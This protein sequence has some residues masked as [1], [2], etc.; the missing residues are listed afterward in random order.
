MRKHHYIVRY[1][2]D[3]DGWWVVTVDGKPGGV[4]CVSQGRSLKQARSRIREA[5]ALC[6]DDEKAAKEAV[7]DEH[8]E[9]GRAVKTRLKRLADT[10]ERL[11]KLR[12]EASHETREAAKILTDQGLSMRDA[13]ELLGVSFQRVQQLLA[14][15]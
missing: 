12:T 11:E 7:L 4:N 14:V 8:I 2:R 3:Q 15:G 9:I 10:R 6:L 5:L 13:A 1:E